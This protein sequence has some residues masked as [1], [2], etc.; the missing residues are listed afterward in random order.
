MQ[1]YSNKFKYID[2]QIP[3]TMVAGPGPLG[4]MKS[5]GRTI[6]IIGGPREQGEM[7]GEEFRARLSGAFLCP[8]E[9]FKIFS[10]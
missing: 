10:F 4:V 1:I 9:E 3:K 7:S 5:W 2:I 6:G 8:A